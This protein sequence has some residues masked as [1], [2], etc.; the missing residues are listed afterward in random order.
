MAEVAQILNDVI[1]SVEANQ[2]AQNSTDMPRHM[3]KYVSRKT[4]RKQQE[5]AQLRQISQEITDASRQQRSQSLKV[6]MADK[7]RFIKMQ[8]ERLKVE[9]EKKLEQENQEKLERERKEA[10]RQE[11]LTKI[12]E[13]LKN[14]DEQERERIK[15]E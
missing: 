7:E 1:T 10:A 11:K 3:S 9:K 6:S 4:I 5:E 8:V 13:Q 2:Y 12:K 15:L 14:R